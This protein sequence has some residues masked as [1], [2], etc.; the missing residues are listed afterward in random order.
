MRVICLHKDALKQLQGLGA[1]VKDLTLLG[2]DGTPYHLIAAT[3]DV[4]S[5]IKSLKIRHED[6]T[7]DIIASLPPIDPAGFLYCRGGR[8]PNGTKLRT[9]YKSRTF[10]AEVRGGLIWIN[11]KT[12]DSPSSA[13]RAVGHGSVNGWTAWE[14]RD[15]ESRRWLPLKRLRS[16]LRNANG[17]SSVKPV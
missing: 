8:I 6:V 3:T 14:Y 10:E 1:E 5:A 9:V 4:A 15:K 2:L 16:K 11:G 17:S 13:A 7:P 12:Y